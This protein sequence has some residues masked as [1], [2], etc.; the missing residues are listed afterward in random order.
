[1]IPKLTSSWIR[2]VEYPENHLNDFCIFK[3]PDDRWHCIGI[4]G[5]GTWASETSLFHCSSNDLYGPYEIHPPLLADLARGSTPNDAP[6]KHAPIVFVKQDTCF[7][8]LRRP[9]G[10][11]LLLKSKDPFHWPTEPDVLFEEN[12]ARD[13]CIQEFE[14]V[15]HWY[16]CQWREMESIGRS[17]IMLRRSR[18]LQDWGET[19]VVHVDTSQESR[20]SHLQSPFV[21]QAA[22]HYWLFVR[23]RSMDNRC[24]TTLFRADAPDRF[25]SGISAWDFEFEGVHAAELVTANGQWHIARVSGPPGAHAGAPEKG[26]WI[27]IASISFDNR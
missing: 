11:N 24:V 16:Y 22:N 12:D 26:G 8:F 15:Y 4:M 25:A 21:V 14:G 19:S 17:C 3:T 5:T 18:N 20:N 2:I 27:E 10:T 13:A 9:P 7:M 1:M 23:N 6:Q